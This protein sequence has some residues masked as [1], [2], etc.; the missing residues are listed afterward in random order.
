MT[1]WSKRKRRVVLVVSLVVLVVVPFGLA[2]G[3]YSTT[4][5]KEITPE[6]MALIR[7][8]HL[9][10][11]I[12]VEDEV[13]DFNGELPKLSAYTSVLLS[14]LRRTRLFDRVDRLEV[15]KTPPDL[16][17]RVEEAISGPA[18]I[19]L[20]TGLTLGLYPTRGESRW[21]LPFS[22]RRPGPFVDGKIVYIQ[23]VYR[24]SDVLG[25]LAVRLNALPNH[26]WRDLEDDPRFIDHFALEIVRNREAIE[27]LAA[28]PRS[29]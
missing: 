9:H 6:Q 26:T 4:R 21:G 8:T 1:V 7:A 15:F 10:L 17:A 25:W 3:C 16:L 5:P 19:P 22:L 27:A 24:G 13:S 14:D 12:G 28:K 18:T 20:V 29:K 23:Y 2:G 11:T